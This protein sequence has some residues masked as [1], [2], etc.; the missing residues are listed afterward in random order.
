MTTFLSKLSLSPI[1]VYQDRDNEWMET[2]NKALNREQQAIKDR[3]QWER[4]FNQCIT[5]EGKLL[6]EIAELRTNL[7]SLLFSSEKFEQTIKQAHRDA[8]AAHR[9][10]LTVAT[11]L[12]NEKK[13]RLSLEV[14]YQTLQRAL[15][16][17]TQERMKLLR[18]NEEL[19][20]IKHQYRRAMHVLKVL[21][22][23]L[24]PTWLFRSLMGLL[25]FDRWQVV[26][27]AV[28]KTAML[29]ENY[30]TFHNK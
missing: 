29:V 23:Y 14:D 12:E 30:E 6:K 27:E 28:D 2:A 25:D 13:A 5:R 8:D 11:R 15:D 9:E 16:T 18:Q 4:A 3:V 17:S 21:Q 26:D 10:Y 1:V 22:T 24:F 7:D 20:E 19:K